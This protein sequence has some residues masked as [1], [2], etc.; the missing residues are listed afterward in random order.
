MFPRLSTKPTTSHTRRPCLSITPWAATTT[1]V[2]SSPLT[3]QNRP[4]TPACLV[5]SS[6]SP[7]VVFPT[8]FP[9]LTCCTGCRQMSLSHP[10][11]SLLLRPS[12]RAPSLRPHH[13][14]LTSLPISK[15]S[16]HTPL[17]HRSAQSPWAHRQEVILPS[18]EY[19]ADTSTRKNSLPLLSTTMVCC[20]TVNPLASL[21]R[22]SLCVP[23]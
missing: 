6:T 21:P 13:L 5:P 18:A 22:S 23:T 15:H 9:C 16:R 8:R 20:A 11:P 19:R 1:T 4:P 7:S 12:P 2:H 17:P 14:T 10:K 3:C